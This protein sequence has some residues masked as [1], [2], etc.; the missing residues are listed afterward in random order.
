MVHQ[1]TAAEPAAVQDSAGQ[2]RG[3]SSVGRAMRSQCIGQGFESPYL[4]QHN[5]GPDLFWVQRYF[6]ALSS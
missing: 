1:V 2:A 5:A 3:Y 4:H 6:F